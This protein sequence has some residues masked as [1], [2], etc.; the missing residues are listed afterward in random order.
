LPKES[1][2][3]AGN[4]RVEA[5]RNG[6]RRLSVARPGLGAW[7]DCLFIDAGLLRC[8]WSNAAEVIPGQLY[9]ANH[10][11]P[12]G[13]ARLVQRWGIRSV[14]NLR[15]EKPCGSTTLSVAAA[16]RLG[17]VHRF[18]A[19]ESRGAPQAGRILHF[20][21]LYHELPRPLL[22]HCKSGA[23]RAGL[24]AGLALLF[25]GDSAAAAARQ[26]SWRFGHVRHSRAGV[27]DAFFAHYAAEAEG[28]IGFLDWVTREYDAAALQHGFAAGRLGAFVNEWLLHRE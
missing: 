2:P 28:R 9:R 23:D 22:I 26:L 8:F 12:G 1:E 6:A 10:P 27:L 5:R 14:V 25:E 3:G 16:E 11:T 18:L 19:F 7:A 20:Y 21:A 13:L 17:L 24:V 4:R 15:G